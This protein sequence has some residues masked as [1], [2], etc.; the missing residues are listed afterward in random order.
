MRT[1]SNVVLFF[2]T[3]AAGFSTTAV[4]S[5]AVHAAAKKNFSE[6][7]RYLG[8]NTQGLVEENSFYS[9]ACRKKGSSCSQYARK[10][11]IDG[12][13][14][15]SEAAL[16]DDVLQAL[17][18]FQEDKFMDREGKRTFAS[19]KENYY[20]HLR[21][22]TSKNTYELPFDNLRGWGSLN[23]PPIRT[24]ASQPGKYLEGMDTFPDRSR[25]EH[26]FF[27]EE[28]QRKIDRVSQTELTAGNELDLLP[29]RDAY[30]AKLALIKST[31]KFLW[32]Q[33][34][35]FFCDPDSEV[36]LNA[37]IGRAQAGVEVR[38]VLEGLWM[39]L[40][41]SGC[42]KKMRDGGIN[43]LLIADSVKHLII[44]VT[45]TK[46][47][48]RDGEEAIFGGKNI[49]AAEDIGDGFNDGY[50]D[51]DAH[52]KSGP[53]ITD[54]MAAYVATWEAEHSKTAKPISD[55]TPIIQA[56]MADERAQGVRGVSVYQNILRD[57]SRRMNGVC[58]VLS[59][60]RGA[61]TETISP[62]LREFAANSSERILLTTPSIRFSSDLS[63]KK[64]MGDYFFQ[65]VRTAANDRGARVD[66][67]TNSMDALGGDT[68]KFTRHFASWLR[69]RG[70]NGLEQ[71]INQLSY[72]LG[73]ISDKKNEKMVRD[74]VQMSP[75]IHAWRYFRYT[76]QKVHMF[77][78]RVVG[79]GSFNLDTFSGSKNH[80]GEMFCM[81]QHLID[82]AEAAFTR[83]V[84]NATPVVR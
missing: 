17:F 16:P 58:R 12:K 36:L 6:L 7:S 81:D 57:P 79:I 80:E 28:F 46:F 71:I 83:D 26:I 38:V 75:N 59:Q 73:E 24:L 50:R 29:G 68:S 65:E 66:L 31:K 69:E 39:R 61:K 35:V 37:M 43:V 42:V 60:S 44:G 32:V 33:N 11:K 22:S 9:D 20:S 21:F 76:H 53:A 18:T 2:L 41:G 54:I 1:K 67:L 10:D 52:V 40:V 63:G 14:W 48:V 23:H 56:R 3:V 74:F 47:W 45:H 34:M 25:D 77:D 15:D 70:Q 49:F 64:M 27:D 72:A 82:Q 5:R 78:R 19:A 13:Y 55:Y 51:T 62:V 84:V 8:D 4:T 30:E